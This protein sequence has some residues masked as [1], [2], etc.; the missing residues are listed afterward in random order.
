MPSS[1]TPTDL[2][3]FRS[4]TSFNAAVSEDAFLL[5]KRKSET[6]LTFNDDETLL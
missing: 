3:V 5:F 6:T 4:K 2:G 1:F